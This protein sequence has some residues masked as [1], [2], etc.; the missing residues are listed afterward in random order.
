MPN[1]RNHLQ[2]SVARV[3]GVLAVG[4]LP[5]V[6]ACGNEASQDD[7]SGSQSGAGGST[8]GGAAGAAAGGGVAAG[9][10]GGSGASGGAGSGVVGGAGGSA[11]AGQGGG[12]GAGAAAGQGGESGASGAAVCPPDEDQ[13]GISD[14]V[15]GK[16]TLLDT[17]KDGTPDYLDLDSDGDGIPDAV[18]GLTG[19]NG[20]LLPQDSD[21]DGTPDFQDTDSD[22][23]GLP[24]A[25]EVYPD[26][27]PY[28]PLKPPADTDGDKYPDYADDD[29]DGD[30][31]PDT[32]ELVNGSAVDTD[33]DG[34]PDHDDID[35]DN[36][37]IPDGLDGVTDLD[38]DGVPNF[39]DTDSDGDGIPDSCEAGMGS[40]QGDTP[41][42]SDQD[43]KYDFLDLDSD[44]DGLLD[45]VED[46]NGSCEID[47]GETDPR[48]GDTDGDGATDLVEVAL[49]CDPTNKFLG[50]GSG[51]P[52]VYFVVPYL[53]DP[54]PAASVV[55]VEV[56]LQKADL[57][58][59]MDTTGTMGQEI[60]GL[61]DGVA[62]II[63]DVG[64]FLPDVQVG[65]AGQ[66]D[67]PVAPYGLGSAG[68]QAFYV[69][70]GGL[71]TADVAKVQAAVASLTTHNGGLDDTAESQVLAMWRALTNQPY[72]YPGVQVP[73]D[74][75]P[76]GRFGSMGFREDAMPILI[77]ITDAAFHNGRRVS[78]PDVLHDPYSFNAQ[79]PDA[80]PTV[81][82][83]LSV[84]SERGAKFI[85]IA[86]D[87][88]HRGGF[89]P[90]EDMAYIADETGSLASPKAFGGTCKTSLGGNP[91]PTPDGPGGTCR[92]IFDTPTTTGVGLSQRVIDGVKALVMSLRI[93]V[94]V[95]AVPDAPS[96]ENDQ[97]DSVDSFV[98]VVEVQSGGIAPLNPAHPCIV[99][100][101]GAGQD[102]WTGPKGVIS[103]PDSV[104]EGA[105]GVAAGDNV[106]YLV[107]PLVNTTVPAKETV[108]A[109]HAIL[110]AKARSG[111]KGPEIDFGAPLDVVFIVPPLPQ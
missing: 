102:Q 52:G 16:S 6:F 103:G 1:T 84:M 81:D 22:N 105:K 63:Q 109:F 18:E 59:I 98:K 3:I 40:K 7:S 28:D 24:D 95:V 99:A 25:K 94:R 19:V 45:S 35:S 38:E 36:D 23:N 26:G 15:E 82:T 44:G 61:K 85:G 89:D 5:W 47:S 101:G 108:Q 110:Q 73:P 62:T 88:G 65:V 46:A 97:V 68:D 10:G 50:P 57:G 55:G 49:G 27:S 71:V 48:S 64:K 56:A 80:A 104:A 67:Y 91:L 70:P 13:D 96:P 86:S 107:T 75:I 9:A 51:C 93:D 53:E 8:T 30:T 33:M 42:D 58:F 21:S 29:N 87:D 76:A 77:S 17:D 2:I 37:S 39:R 66:D 43:G 34:L 83:L 32:A 20:C 78:A 4:S 11:G 72:Q 74:S 69:P 14:E 90:Y 12:A 111:G 60:A 41:I 92:L 106:C 79:Q 31:L 54:F 100:S